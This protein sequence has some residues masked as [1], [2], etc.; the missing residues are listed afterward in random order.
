[1]INMKLG[2][3]VFVLIVV[4]SVV[5]V[6]HTPV[7][8]GQSAKASGEPQR[9]GGASPPSSYAKQIVKLAFDNDEDRV[10]RRNAIWRSLSNAKKSPQFVMV[11][12]TNNN[13]VTWNARS[14]SFNCVRYRGM[15]AIIL[16]NGEGR[17]QT[18]NPSAIS[19]Q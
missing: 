12:Y 15:D 2:F 5:V 8:N 13:W 17:R 11:L 7:V 6:L 9:C 18:A 16:T 1:L 10:E 19:T 14:L 3:N 4:C